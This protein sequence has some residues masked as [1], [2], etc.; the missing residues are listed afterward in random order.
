[1]SVTPRAKWMAST[2]ADSFGVSDIEAQEIF[3]SK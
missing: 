1:M 3:T 2:V